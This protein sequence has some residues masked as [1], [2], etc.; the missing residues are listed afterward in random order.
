M[1][2]RTIQGLILA[3]IWLVALPG[4]PASLSNFGAEQPVGMA[5]FRPHLG[6]NEAYSEQWSHGVWTPDG[7]FVG[8]DF[9]ISNLGIGD[10]KGGFRLELKDPS[11]KK[12]E[13]KQE[14]D[15]DEWSAAKEGFRLTFGSQELSGDASGLRIKVRCPKLS[16]DLQFANVGPSVRPGDGTLSMEDDGEVEGSYHLMIT[17]PRANVTGQV[18]QDGR[19]IAIAG[20]GFCDHS[21]SDISPEKLARRWFRF[22]LINPDISI[23]MAEIEATR[24]LGSVQR[25]WILVYDAQGRV[26][27]TARTRFEYDGFVSQSKDGGYSIPRRVRL[28]AAD[29]GNTLTGTLLM[30]GVKEIRDPTANLDG[31]RRA[32]VQQFSK[33]RDYSLACSYQFQLKQAGQVKELKGEGIYRFVFVNP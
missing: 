28:V 2:M 27:A 30:T 11:G 14:F 17:S 19:T 24:E 33:P 8:V 12:V 1:N 10:H 22:K 15:D 23:V 18:V 20:P 16:A 31:V 9:A 3:A 5:D 7:Y 6:D 29:G 13:C 4:W 21:Y 32:I 26:L 25:G